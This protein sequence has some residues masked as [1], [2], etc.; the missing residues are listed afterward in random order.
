MQIKQLPSSPH[1]ES[2][3][4]S[5]KYL[6]DSTR[7]NHPVTYYIAKDSIPI[8]VVERPEFKHM[9]LKHNPRYQVPARWHFTDY[10]IPR[11]Y[12][13]V[14]DNIVAELL[15][16]VTFLW[17][18]PIFGVVINVMLTLTVHFISINWNLKSFCL[19]TAALYEDHTSHNIADTIYLTY[20]RIGT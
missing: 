20:L 11:L 7:A 14:K 16:E 3:A 6:P 12:S 2:I 5:V 18:L 15:K 13:H 9:L 10:E 19:D 1:S 8:S 4:C 17:L